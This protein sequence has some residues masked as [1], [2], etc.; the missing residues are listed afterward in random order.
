ML[1]HDGARYDEIVKCSIDNGMTTL[2]SE[3]IRLLCE[4]KTTFEEVAKVIY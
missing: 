1:I 4:Q 3:A 2:K